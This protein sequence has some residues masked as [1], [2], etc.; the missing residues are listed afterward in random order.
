M[1]YLREFLHPCVKTN[2][3]L[4]SLIECYYSLYIDALSN[5]SGEVFLFFINLWTVILFSLLL[6][7]LTQQS[8]DHLLL[9]TDCSKGFL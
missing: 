8:N 4:T 3:Y 2:H 1:C 9:G 5:S 6:K 7:A